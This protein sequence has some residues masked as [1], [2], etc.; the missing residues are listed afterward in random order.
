V[1]GF[2]ISGIYTLTD[3]ERGNSKFQAY[4]D[5]RTDGGGWMLAFKQSHFASGGVE[6]DAKLFG[7]EPLLHEKFNASTVSS[8][9]G[10]GKP[11]QMLFKS[12][13]RGTWFITKA[14][15]ANYQYWRIDPTPRYCLFRK[16]HNVGDEWRL[17]PLWATNV[18]M[19]DDANIQIMGVPHPDISAITIG[20]FTV[21]QQGPQCMEPNC[22]KERHGRYNGACQNGNSGLGNWMIFQR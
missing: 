12:G 7:S 14:L 4:C 20:R 8:L 2:A 13:R 17:S 6:F 10:Y 15:E 3:T 1:A 16:L 22:A 11:K 5:M 21:V 18:P 9:I 19:W